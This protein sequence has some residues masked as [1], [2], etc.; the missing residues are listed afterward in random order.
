[1]RASRIL[2]PL[3]ILFGIIGFGLSTQL[4]LS[5]RAQTAEGT[6]AP[7]LEDIPSQKGDSQ[8][9]LLIEEIG[10]QQ[11]ALAQNLQLLETELAGLEENLRQARIFVSRGG[12]R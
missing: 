7:A 11:V 8:V 9:E 12:G 1:M 4:P 10:A 3:I 6:A 2:G 5:V